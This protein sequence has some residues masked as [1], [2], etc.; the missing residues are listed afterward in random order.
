MVRGIT[1]GVKLVAHVF[2]AHLQFLELSFAPGDATATV[3]T[4]RPL[5]ADELAPVS[6]RTT[7]LKTRQTNN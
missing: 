5:D 2:P 1:G 4:K 6:W 7:L 3:R